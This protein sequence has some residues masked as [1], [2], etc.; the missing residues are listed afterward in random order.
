LKFG[1]KKPK[2][3][4]FGQKPSGFLDLPNVFLVF[5]SIFHRLF[6]KSEFLVEFGFLSVHF[7]MAQ[8]PRQGALAPEAKA[9]GASLLHHGTSAKAGVNVH[10]GTSAKAVTPLP[11]LPASAAC[12]KV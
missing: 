11:L 5:S 1:R 4:P 12:T 7:T 6:F 2:T 10:Y 8:L 9:G 3:E